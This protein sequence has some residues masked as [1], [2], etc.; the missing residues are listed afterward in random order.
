MSRISLDGAIERFFYDACGRVASVTDGKGTVYLKNTYDATTGRLSKQVNGNGTSVSYL[1]DK[2]GR[3]VSIEHRDSNGK[4]AESLRYCYDADGRCIRAASL[5]GEERYTYDK[6]GQLTAVDYPDMANEAF[7]YDAVGN[8]TTANGA[9][10]TVNNLNQYTAI[11]GGTSL[12]YDKDG[13]LTKMT[14]AK[15]T[16]SYFYDTLNRLV[17][18]TNTTAGIRWSCTYDVFG[19]RVSVTDNGVTTERMYLQ[20]SLP[21]V[22]AEYVN[23][24]LK[25]RHI[26]VGAVRVADVTGTTGVSPVD[27]GST[28]YYHADLIGSTRLVTDGSGAIVNRRAYKAFGETRTGGGVNNSAGYVG[29]LG[30]ETDSTGLLFM[31]NRYYSPSLGRFIQMD[32]IGLSGEDVNLYRYCGNAPIVW[33]D[34]VGYKFLGLTGKQWAIGAA[35]VAGVALGAVAIGSGIV[36]LGAAYSLTGTA[37]LMGN[38]LAGVGAAWGIAAAEIAIGAAMEGIVAW[39]V[40]DAFG[41]KNAIPESTFGNN[42]I[43]KRIHSDYESTIN[44]GG[45][46]GGGSGSGG[47]G[48]NPEPLPVIDDFELYDGSVKKV[49]VS[50]SF[51][52]SFEWVVQIDSLYDYPATFGRSGFFVDGALQSPGKIIVDGDIK[53]VREQ[54]T[55]TGEGPHTLQWGFVSLTYLPVECKVRNIKIVR[56]SKNSVMP[57]QFKTMRS[58][59]GSVSAMAAMSMSVKKTSVKSLADV[60]WVGTVTKTAKA[61]AS[62][63]PRLYCYERYVVVKDSSYG[64]AL[65]ADDRNAAIHVSGLPAGFTFANGE[66]RGAAS[67]VGSATLTITAKSPSG[68]TIKR[69]PFVVVAAPKSFTQVK[70]WS[71]AFNANGGTG[72]MPVQRFANGI[73][74]SLNANAFA[75][76]GCTFKGWA[77]SADGNVVYSDR[78][79][80]SVASDMTL[81]AVWMKNGGGNAYLAIA[82]PGD[83]NQCSYESAARTNDSLPIVCDSSWTVSANVNWIALR[84]TGGT[85]SG[86]VYFD[87][88]ANSTSELRVGTITVTRGGMT[89]TKTIVQTGV[90]KTYSIR[91][92]K[93]DGT[94]TV[95]TE[96]FLCGIDE[97]LPALKNG[98]GWARN[99]FVFKGWA[100]S[101]ANANAGKIWKSDWA[102][103]TDAAAVGKTLDVWAVWGVAPGYYAIRFNKND[104]SGAWRTVAFKHGKSSALPSCAKGLGWT[105]SGYAFVGWAVSAEKANAPGVPANIWRADQAIVSTP[106][107]AGSMLDVYASWV[108]GYVVRFHK[109]TGETPEIIKIQGIQSG[110]RTRLAAVKNG[111]GWTRTGFVFKGWATS[112]AKEKKK[113]IWKGDWSYVKDGTS[114]GKTLDVWAVWDV[115]PGYYAI[116]FNKN[117]GSGAWRTI[118]FPYGKARALPTCVDGLGWTRSGYAFVGWAVSAAKANAPGVPANIWKTDQALVSTPVAAGKMMDVYASWVK[119]YTVRFHKNTGETPEVIK[120]QGIQTGVKTRLAAVKNGLGWTRTGFVFKGW[121]TSPANAEAKKIWK[122]DWS[123]VKDGTSAGKTLDVWAVWGVAPGY[124]VIR[125][126]KND[127]SGASRAV[128]FQHGQS[129]T[130][131][132]CASGLGWSRGGFAFVGW[133]VSEEKAGSPGAPANIWKPDQGVVSAPVSAGSVLDVYAS[134]VKGYAIRFHKNTGATPEIIKAQ[135]IQSG[136]RTRLAALKNGLGWERNGFVFRGWATSMANA[137]ARKV[138]KGDWSYVMDATSLGKVLNVWAIW[139]GTYDGSNDDFANARTI[140]GSSGSSTSSNKDATAERNEPILGKYVYARNSLWWAWTAPSSGMVAFS[141]SGTA[142]DTVMGVYAGSSLATLE[143]ITEN[144]DDGSGGTSTCVFSAKAH[145]VYYIAVA[146]YNVNYSGTVKLSWLMTGLGGVVTKTM[147]AAPK[148]T[149]TGAEVSHCRASEGRAGENVIFLSGELPDGSG[150]YSLAFDEMSGA[151]TVFLER[152]EASSSFACMVYCVEGEVGRFV[153]ALESGE[154]LFL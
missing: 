111:L 63:G 34:P 88:S 84:T 74:Q 4:I 118:A 14:D 142:F 52:I 51:T 54:V 70:S 6:D 26:V 55:V 113:K 140:G 75:C 8:R 124:Y 98:L 131:P 49:A 112:K 9:N 56:L 57:A 38:S 145:T 33:L 15:G 130:L 16:T 27:S 120:T 60:E 44:I 94:G 128:A 21:S 134:W 59:V 2:L 132:T 139:E 90:P 143:T 31:R 80:V 138:W 147:T 82:G 58:K 10:Y 25:E 129:M 39:G 148:M 144:D 119:G 47:G 137:K 67:T 92:N 23:G 37:L 154:V 12:S 81:Y 105:R 32:P 46:G 79:S 62:P 91:F 29:T 152:G 116:K 109:N 141:T 18:V 83:G 42:M 96:K 135:G 3:V 65:S 86:R 48:D 43:A 115:A 125:F 150:V 45:S 72:A 73:A 35:A 97:Q 100:T 153:V 136:V 117:D 36:G 24:Q 30:V 121:A 102:Y 28:R 61:T 22:A 151:G 64:F 93:N 68:T 104:G 41:E 76:S 95:S 99:G 19:N 7:A 13:N 101:L 126:N 146:G 89:Y 122:G 78:Q 87:L 40:N 123:Y 66:I 149:T 5:L 85:G 69:V 107:A 50:G 108:A 127:G 106:V 11:S 110:V 133:S 53:V 103:V 71:V 77:K 1:Y 114:A 20:G 17:A